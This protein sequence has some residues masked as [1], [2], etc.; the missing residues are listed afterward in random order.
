MKGYF[1]IQGVKTST[2]I[3]HYFDLSFDVSGNYYEFHNVRNHDIEKFLE[4]VEQEFNTEQE[5]G[6]FYAEEELFVEITK[7]SEVFHIQISRVDYDYNMQYLYDFKLGIQDMK[8][9][10]DD[11][12]KILEK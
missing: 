3:T 1:M 7:E 2:I 4:I 12:I 5:Y 11:L 9:C 10:I 6:S 8:T